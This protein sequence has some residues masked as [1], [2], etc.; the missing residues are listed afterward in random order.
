MWRATISGLRAHKLRLALTALSVVLGVAFVSGTLILGDTLNHTFDSLFGQVYANVSVEVRQPTGIKTQDGSPL[1]RPVPQALVGQIASTPGVGAAEGTIQ[2]N[3]QLIDK[4]GKAIAP[5]APTFG[6]NWLTSTAL[7]VFKLDKGQAPTKA[8]D[9][10][11]DAGTASKYNFNVGDQ[12]TILASGP[13]ER[14]TVVGTAKFGKANNLA[15]ATYAL[16]T[17]PT[18]QRVLDRPGTF[19]VIDVLAKPGTSSASLGNTLARQLP[20][21]YEAVTGAQVAKDNAKQVKSGIGIF[22]TFLLVFALISLFVG[23]FIILNTFSILVAQRTRELGLLR[24]LGASRRQV[25]VS[26]LAEATVVGFIASGVGILAG[27]GVA[28]GLQALFN[29]IGLSLPSYGTVFLPRTIIV[30]LIIGVGVSLVASVNPALKASRI[31]PVEAIGGVTTDS[32]GSLRRRGIFG[33]I[34]V[35]LGVAIMALGLFSHVS[36]RAALVGAGIAV[37][38]IGVAILAPIVARPIAGVLGRPLPRLSRGV[39][40]HKDRTRTSGVL[41]RQNAMRN[42]RRTSATAAALMVGLALVTM[43]SIFGESAKASVTKTINQDFSA[44]YVIKANFQPFSPSVEPKIAA[45]P[46]VGAVSPERSAN[47]KSGTSSLTLTGVNPATIGQ[48][49]HLDIKSGSLSALGRNQLLVEEKA[50]KN[51]GWKVGSLV[52]I[53]FPKTGVQKVTV[54]GTFKKNQLA[55]NYLLSTSVIDPGVVEHVDDVVLVKAAPGVAAT[56]LKPAL[57]KTIADYPSLTASDAAGVKQQFKNQLNTLL[58]IIYALLGLAV[59]IAVLGIIN[60]LVLSVVERTRELGL[61]RAVGM[62]RRQVKSMVRGESVVIALFGAILGLVMGTGFAFALT[63]ALSSGGSLG[64]IA[65]PYGSLVLFIVFAALAGVVAAAW[66]ARRAARL[67]VL[68]ALAFE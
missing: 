48:V 9:V 4:H 46:G 65:I 37:T 49:L 13:P 45:V 12:I 5:P 58:G 39:V 26:T 56:S 32:A 10:V 7:S 16:F 47:V 30:G 2:G 52:P 35:A 23:S 62:L 68:T 19:D 1:Y 20:K 3:A 66:P 41:A 59:I 25:M 15:G 21:G 51:K 57:D 61:L 14:F 42:P 17:T 55:G 8:S 64:T 28:A 34:G 22:T 38:F 33:S 53:D 11:L 43:F 24:A 18:A 60:T 50:A 63:K 31:A 29:L 54:G 27:L 40:R 6:G 36:G 44:D 67:D